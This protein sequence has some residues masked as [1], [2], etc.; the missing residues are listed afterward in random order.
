MDDSER[1][2]DVAAI[3]AG[4]YPDVHTGL[5][6]TPL[7]VVF[8]DPQIASVG[9]TIQQIEEQFPGGFAA[10][11]VN[12]EGQGRSRIMGR[13]LGLLRVYRCGSAPTRRPSFPK[14]VVQQGTLNPDG[15]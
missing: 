12:F 9:L 15:A 6:S 2:V 5:R 13:N 4:S 7:S 1:E 11:S 3:G 10:G 14:L 8:T